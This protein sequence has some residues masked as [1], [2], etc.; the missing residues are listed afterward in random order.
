MKKATLIKTGITVYIH[1]GRNPS[2]GCNDG[3][4]VVSKQPNST[5]VFCAKLEDLKI[6]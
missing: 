1:E 4:V 5:A 2:H 3:M 6:A